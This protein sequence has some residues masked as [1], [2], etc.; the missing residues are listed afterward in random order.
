MLISFIKDDA[1]GRVLGQISHLLY[2][3]S[4]KPKQTNHFLPKIILQLPKSVIRK[5]ILYYLCLLTRRYIRKIVIIGGPIHPLY[6]Q[7]EIGLGSSLRSAFK[8]LAS[9][10]A[11]QVSNKVKVFTLELAKAE[12]KTWYLLQ[13]KVQGIVQ[14]LLLT[15]Q[16]RLIYNISIPFNP[17]EESFSRVPL[18]PTLP[19]YYPLRLVE[20]HPFLYLLGI[21]LYS[22]P[23]NRI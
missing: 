18:F 17:R 1:G 10:I 3:L 8:R 13:N 6:P 5:G 4:Y 7:V 22:N 23:F 21:Q 11:H 14:L 12:V 9:F 15:S 19:L 16:P 2:T 20:P